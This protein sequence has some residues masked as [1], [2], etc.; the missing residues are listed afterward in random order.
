[1]SFDEQNNAIERE[2]ISAKQQLSTQFDLDSSE[3]FLNR[4]L[5]WLEFNRRVLHEG[6]DSRTPLL[7][8]VFFL[9]VVG[10]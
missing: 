1:M 6:Q 2:P 5:T 7:E 3:L 4:E 9:S 8:R 10:S